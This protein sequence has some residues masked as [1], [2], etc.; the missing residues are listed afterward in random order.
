[1][2]QWHRQAFYVLLGLNAL[3]GVG[4]LVRY[5]AL[6]HRHLRRNVIT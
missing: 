4:A 1:M 3:L 5:L 2:T 6:W